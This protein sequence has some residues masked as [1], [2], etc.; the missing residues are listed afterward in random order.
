[1]MQS[2]MGE[3]M[4]EEHRRDLATLRATDDPADPATSN[5]AS[6]ATSAHPAHLALPGGPQHAATQRS[7]PSPRVRHRSFGRHIG[8]LLI[9]AGTRLGGASISPS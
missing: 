8:A 2:W 1:M 9:R 4:A 6:H 3:R 5:W 7:S